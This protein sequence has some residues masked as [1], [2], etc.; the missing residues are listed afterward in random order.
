MRGAPEPSG[1][2][3]RG[4]EYAITC[5]DADKWYLWNAGEKATYV[6]PGEWRHFFCLEPLLSVLTP[7]AP[8]ESRT[9]RATF[10]VHGGIRKKAD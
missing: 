10:R 1:D 9:Y 4:R 7:L 5:A 2:P 3:A 6:A 8:G